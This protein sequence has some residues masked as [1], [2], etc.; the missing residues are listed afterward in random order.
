MVTWTCKT[1][2]QFLSIGLSVHARKIDWLPSVHFRRFRHMIAL[3][4]SVRYLAFCCVWSCGVFCLWIPHSLCISFITSGKDYFCTARRYH[5][6]FINSSQLYM[7]CGIFAQF[8]VPQIEMLFSIFSRVM[9]GS[10]F[11]HSDFFITT[12]CMNDTIA[13]ILGDYSS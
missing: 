12:E 5:G 3:G 11:S 7:T 2:Q 8:S 1:R 9:M 10:I 13:V 6:K 4:I